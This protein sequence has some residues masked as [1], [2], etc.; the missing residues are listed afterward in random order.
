LGKSGHSHSPQL[1]DDRIKCRKLLHQ[2][3][4][5]LPYDDGAGRAA[6]LQDL[7]G[8]Y[9]KGERQLPRWGWDVHAQ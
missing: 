6:V 4:T 7:L 1:V 2:L 3:N 9:D 5:A 8:S